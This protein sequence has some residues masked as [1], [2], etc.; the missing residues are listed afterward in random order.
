VT[1]KK[2]INVDTV[3]RGQD[4]EI[5]A[6]VDELADISVPPA[7]STPI[8]KVRLSKKQLAELIKHGTIGGK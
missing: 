1:E 3:P 7:P 4:P 2:F 6:F 8:K 5:D